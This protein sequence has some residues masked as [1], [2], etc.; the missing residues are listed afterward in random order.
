MKSVVIG[1]RGSKLALT[2]SNWIADELR[3]LYP[4]LDVSIKVIKTLGDKMTTASL[5]RLAGESKGLFVKEIEEAL[6]DGSVDLAVHSLKD[7]PTELPSDLMLGMIP[8]REDPRDALISP[9][10]VKSI[11]D[12]PKEGVVG[13]SSLR[14]RVQLKK[15]RPDLN[16]VELRGNVDTRLRKLKEQKLDGVVLATAGL[17]RM[18]LSRHIAYRFSIEEMVPAIGQGALAIE[19]RR[20]DSDIRE[21]IDPLNHEATRLAVL[22]ERHF[23]EALG[24]GCQVPMGAHAEETAEQSTFRAFICD[25]DGNNLVAQELT[26][27][28]GEAMR[29]ARES[30]EYFMKKGAVAILREA[31]V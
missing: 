5:V 15:R 2:Q 8:E 12:L 23:L 6:L 19:V 3:R 28:P 25:P 4:S 30:A 21:L 11:D 26:G 14:R 22:A 1:S 16:I 27:E 13:T 7:V 18:G 17:R 24:G 10:R 20:G 29:L 9:H 31:E